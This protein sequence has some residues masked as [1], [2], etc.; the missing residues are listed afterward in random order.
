MFKLLKYAKKYTVPALLSPVFMIGEVV[1]E[2]MIPLVM[3]DI[4]NL[5]QADGGM[6]DDSMNQI[7]RLGL[8][9]LLL[10][11]GSLVCGTLA[12][13]VASVAGMGFGSTIRGEMIGR[14]QK[15]SFSNIDRFSTA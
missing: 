11:L 13:R 3:A 2:L 5:V 6:S 4:V 12:A 15:F 14:I 7:L 9:M 1:L 10:A 8:K